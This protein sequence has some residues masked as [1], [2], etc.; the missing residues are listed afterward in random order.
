MG[1]GLIYGKVVGKVLTASDVI[2]LGYI[3][4]SFAPPK[5]VSA[6]ICVGN[7]NTGTYFGECKINGLSTDVDGD[8]RKIYAKF[9]TAIPEG[10]YIYCNF[11]YY[12][13]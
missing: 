7:K 13:E 12:L 1:N 3:N 2:L 8:E 6:S 9:T 10:M 5:S 11:I 4:S